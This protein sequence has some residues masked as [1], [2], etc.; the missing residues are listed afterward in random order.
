M[1]VPAGPYP[2]EAEYEELIGNIDSYVDAFVA[3]LQSSFVVM[4][5]GGGFVEYERFRAAYECLH[6]VTGGFDRLSEE[7]ALRAVGEDPLA[8]VVLRTMTGLTAPELANLACGE[9][10]VR[11]EQSS[12]RGVDKRAR[13]GKTVLELK[14][15]RTRQCATSMVQMAVRLLERG[16][17]AV[18][19]EAIHRLDKI[20][21][22]H[23]LRDVEALAV[24]RVPY[25][26][27]LYE[28]LL[29][30]P[31]ATHRDA[32][33]E[34]VGGVLEET[35]EVQLLNQG[36]EFHRTAR[37]EHFQDWDQAPDFVIPD[38]D[39]PI[40]VI[41]A[42]LAEDD[43]TARDKVTRVQHLDEL[44]NK[45]VR[46]GLPS[47]EVIACVDGRGFG[48]RRQDVKKLLLATRG[49]LFTLG[50]IERLVGASSLHSL[51]E[52]K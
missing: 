31:F 30:R 43:G 7:N 27:L 40:A 44:R 26:A 10:G 32:V 41:E 36:V 14:A 24:G 48:I 9:F 46:E 1:A 13:E 49:K 35:V 47:F 12:A 23:G 19:P 25:E 3:A 39:N 21:T 2:F 4:P 17:Q 16:A 5:R 52:R 33:S 8:L 11:I 18:G 20:D 22:K 51:A 50:T 28:R 15:A 29:G 38:S 34:R 45:R 42:K 6:R 37:G